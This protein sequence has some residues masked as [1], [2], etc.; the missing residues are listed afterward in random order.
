MAEEYVLR[1]PAKLE[2]MDVILAF[3]SYLLDINGC[4]TKTRTQLRIAIEELYVNVTLYAYPDGD[5]W[6]EIRGSVEDGVAT[7]TLID[8]G[9]PFDPLAKEDPDTMLSGE[10][11]EIGGLGIFMVK[12]TMDE[13]TYEYRDGCNRLKMRKRL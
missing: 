6:A 13:M 1:I 4:S 10:D 11:R 8:S 12:T 3:V 5:G 2:G 7:F 9:R